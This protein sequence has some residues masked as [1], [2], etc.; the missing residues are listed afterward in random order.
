[1]TDITSLIRVQAGKQIVRRAVHFIVH[2]PQGGGHCL[3]YSACEVGAKRIDT[4]LLLNFSTPTTV[5]HRERIP[6]I[7]SCCGDRRS[8]G[9][10]QS[11]RN[12]VHSRKECITINRGHAYPWLGPCLSRVA[13]LRKMR[14]DMFSQI[15]RFLYHVNKC[16]KIREHGPGE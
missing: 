16:C 5:N 3:R 15:I 14:C 11:C 7:Q 2:R 13:E 4:V 8:P 6:C 10:R 12:Y 1:M 9:P